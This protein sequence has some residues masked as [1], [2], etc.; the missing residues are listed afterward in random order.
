MWF[1]GPSV[2]FTHHNK[3]LN[4]CGPPDRCARSHAIQQTTRQRTAFDLVD[5]LAADGALSVIERAM[6]HGRLSVTA[7]R[8]VA[9]GKTFHRP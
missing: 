1:P 6:R 8:E 7:L 4:E 3:Y 9:I 2:R 5:H